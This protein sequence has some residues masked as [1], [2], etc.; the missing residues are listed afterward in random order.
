[1]GQSL[2]EVAFWVFVQ[3]I[4]KCV[5]GV[6]NFIQKNEQKPVDLRFQGRKVFT[7]KYSSFVRL[8]DDFTRQP[9]DIISDSRV[10]CKYFYHRN[11]LILNANCL[12]LTI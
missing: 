7:V 10:V 6:F 3:L 2:Y 9:M 5:L 11:P 12:C 4:L 8:L 1:M